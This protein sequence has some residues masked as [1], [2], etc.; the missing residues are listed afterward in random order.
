M[1]FWTSVGLFFLWFIIWGF[2]YLREVRL[3]AEK[4][5]TDHK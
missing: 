4:G 3:A 1:I 5:D 2:C